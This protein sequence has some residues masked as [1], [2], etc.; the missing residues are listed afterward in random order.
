MYEYTTLTQPHLIRVLEL[1]PTWKRDA[2]LV[3]RL[4]EVS[5]EKPPIFDALSYAWESQSLDQTISCD[6]ETLLIS[7]TCKAALFRLRQKTRRRLLWINQICI[8]QTSME[9]KNHQVAIMGEI[10]SRAR[11]TVVWLGV[12]PISDELLWHGQPI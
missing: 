10:Y 1:R 5:I 9:E 11:R 2:D 8:N 6:G 3:I 12:S 7:A 4:L